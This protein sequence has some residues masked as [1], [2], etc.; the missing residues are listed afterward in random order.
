MADSKKNVGTLVMGNHPAAELVGNL[1]ITTLSFLVV[2]LLGEYLWNNILVK[3]TTIAKPAKNVWQVLG[4]MVL[5][6]LI[7]S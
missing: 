5:V 4:V 3:V 7:F 6:K 2:L 1:V